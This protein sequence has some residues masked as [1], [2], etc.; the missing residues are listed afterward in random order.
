MNMFV[1]A[2][3]MFVLAAVSPV[4]MGQQG[5][6]WS[7][8][9]QPADAA[10]NG[11]HYAVDHWSR[12]PLDGRG[13]YGYDRERRSRLTSRER[14]GVTGAMVGASIG[15]GIARGRGALIGAGTGAVIGLIA[16]RE[17]DRREERE[18]V[19]YV[20]QPQVQ[21]SPAPQPAPAYKPPP[22][23][24]RVVKD[25]FV[26]NRAGLVVD[27]YDGEEYIGRMKPNGFMRVEEPVAGYRAVAFVPD[28]TGNLQ[29]FE[30]RISPAG[31]LRGWL[32]VAPEVQ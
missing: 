17:R 19:A 4:A 9:W 26:R 21:S 5:F 11:I 2:V 28:N 27:L 23:A 29:E 15:A 22:P 7:R 13:G 31:N 24:V 3:S 25:W 6:S 1:F 10:L 30:T 20:P 32:I 14:A 18:D 12:Q 16:G 8:G